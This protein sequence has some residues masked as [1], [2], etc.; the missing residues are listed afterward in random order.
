MASK[1]QV[2]V[3]LKT[4]SPSALGW[5]LRVETKHTCRFGRI[6]DSGMSVWPYGQSPLP[7]GLVVSPLKLKRM[8][9]RGVH[10]A[11]E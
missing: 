11:G 7:G 1:L 5:R 10:A 9:V 6:T 4:Q 3:G 2:R 8:R